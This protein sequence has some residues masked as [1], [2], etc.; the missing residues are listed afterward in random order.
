MANVASYAFHNMPAHLSPLERFLDPVT[1]AELDE[2]SV[3]EGWRCLD[4]A[5]GGGSVTAMLSD[6]VGPDGTVVAI[7]QDVHMLTPRDNVEIYLQD[8]DKREPLPADGPFDLIHARLL[9]HHLAHRREVVH[10]LAEELRPGGWLMLGE[11]VGSVPTVM[12]APGDEEAA[13]FCR[14]LEGLYNVLGD[15][16]IDLT[17]GENVHG[18]MMEAG[19]ESV[20][21]RW[22]AETWTGGSYGCMLAKNNVTQKREQ[23]VAAGI[24]AE[25]VDRFTEELMHDPRLVVRSHIFC[26]IRGQRPG[27]AANGSAG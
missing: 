5:A 13:L 27:G 16:G 3:H 6:A 22:F 10:D 24:A 9:T 25:D 26:S 18:A 12:S 20:R 17:W 23:L 19:L 11:F 4:L 15:H 1:Q 2:I 21:T 14:V 7:D 8:M